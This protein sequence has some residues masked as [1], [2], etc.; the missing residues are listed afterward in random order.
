MNKSLHWILA[1][2]VIVALIT[3][4]S[5]ML[6]QGAA[7]VPTGTASIVEIASE[8]PAESEEIPESLTVYSTQNPEKL[9]F[10]SQVEVFRFTLN[11]GEAYS[12]RYLTLRAESA[13]LLPS[14][15]KDWQVFEIQK[16][17]IDYSKPVGRGENWQEKDLRLRFF[18][19]ENGPYLAPASKQEFL[20]TTRVLSDPNATENPNLTVQ[21]PVDPLMDWA[22]LRGHITG[23]WLSVEEWETL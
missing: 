21:I 5:N 20:V 9:R 22:W 15:P 14:E 11:S 8:T 10:G 3:Q 18:S 17:G 13:G 7:S 12:L 6:D 2:F 23:S 1:S 16:D 4:V 19:P